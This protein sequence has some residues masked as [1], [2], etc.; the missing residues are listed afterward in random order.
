MNNEK[1]YKTMTNVGAGD[2]ALGIVVLLTGVVAG[3]LMIINGARLLK[4]KSDLI[5]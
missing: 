4:G 3:V 5:F 2:L 1:I